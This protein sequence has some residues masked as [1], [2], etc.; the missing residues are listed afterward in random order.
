MLERRALIVREHQLDCGVGSGR[1]IGS[2][3]RANGGI[4]SLLVHM[5]SS[6]LATSS[7]TM[8]ARCLEV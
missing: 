2:S 4:D 8:L 6:P 7:R 5:A 3:A 1:G